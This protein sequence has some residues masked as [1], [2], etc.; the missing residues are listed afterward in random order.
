MLKD[1][2]LLIFDDFGWKDP[3]QPEVVSSPELGI[4]TFATMYQNIYDTIATGYQVVLRKK[5]NENIIKST[6]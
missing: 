5:S 4:R 6:F 3:A 2:G 1:G